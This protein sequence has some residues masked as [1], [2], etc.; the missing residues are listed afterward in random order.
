[1]Q[2]RF[3]C[4]SF[5]NFISEISFGTGLVEIFSVIF[6]G[7]IYSNYLKGYNKCFYLCL[8]YQLL[9]CYLVIVYPRCNNKNLNLATSAFLFSGGRKIF[10]K[11]LSDNAVKH[12]LIYLPGFL[13]GRLAWN[14]SEVHAII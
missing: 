10:S 3:Y 6:G 2:F 1:M 8:L 9:P 12:I 7:D 11:G 13:V 5:I 4:T 14:C